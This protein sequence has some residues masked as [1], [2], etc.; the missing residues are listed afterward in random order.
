[1]VSSQVHVALARVALPLDEAQ[2]EFDAGVESKYI[3]WM[4]SAANVP[5]DQVTIVDSAP[6]SGVVYS[7]VAFPRDNA[8]AIEAFEGY[9]GSSDFREAGSAEFGGEV[10]G[11][12]AA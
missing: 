4:A 3:S 7:T 2:E 8:E 5:E 6:S 11:V 1:M 12:S 9:V 10:D